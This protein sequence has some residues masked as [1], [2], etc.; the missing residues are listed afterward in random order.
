MVRVVIT[1][2]Y[3]RVVINQRVREA[4]PYFPG[5]VDDTGLMMGEIMASTN[6]FCDQCGADIPR[7]NSEFCTHCGVVIPS[8]RPEQDR[9]TQEVL[10]SGEAA[11]MRVPLDVQQYLRRRLFGGAIRNAVIM[12]SVM[13]IIWGALS[14]ALPDGW[15]HFVIDLGAFLVTVGIATFVILTSLKGLGNPGWLAWVITGVIWF[16]TV[17]LVRSVEMAV[18]EAIF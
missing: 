16:A 15:W 8:N 17:P 2:Y 7:A 18:L 11:D 9:L 10:E 13:A 12:L 14:F 5:Q 3:T 6:R 4:N 1:S